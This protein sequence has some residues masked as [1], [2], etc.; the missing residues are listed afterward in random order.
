MSGKVKLIIG[1]N[2]YI[3]RQLTNKYYSK[4]ISFIAADKMIDKK[5]NFHKLDLRNTRATK[6]FFK[7]LKK[8]LSEVIL[9]GTHS[10]IAYRDNFNLSFFEDFRSLVNLIDELK[11]K[12]NPKL[13][14]FSSSYVYSGMN[15]R[16]K[17]KV[18]EKDILKP[19]HNFGYAKLFLKI[20]LIDFIKI[21]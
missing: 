15:S 10:A 20:I 6:L 13:I 3:G 2:G 12:N 18:D 14:Y 19:S 9:L 8:K 1:A 16:F 21:I 4:K 11:K 5:K 7:N 17:K